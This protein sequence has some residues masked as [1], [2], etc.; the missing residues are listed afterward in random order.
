M[1]CLIC[2]NQD[3]I[4]K[5]SDYKLEIKSD[6]KYFKNCSIYNCSDCDFG[7][8]Y[9]FPSNENLNYFYQNIY[10]AADRPPFWRTENI[11]ELDHLLI[12]DKNLN[13]LL[14]A[15]SL[16]NFNKINSIL[17]FGSGYGDLGFLIKKKFPHVKLFS[18]ENDKY[19]KSIL[20]ERGYK[21]FSSLDEINQKFDLVISL[22]SLEHL[23]NTDVFSKF[24][25]ILNTEGLIFFEVPNCTQEYFDGRIY[26]SPHLLFYT[27]KSLRKLAQIKHYNVLNFSH[28]S[29]S[30]ANDHKYQSDSQEYYYKLKNSKISYLNIKKIMKK[31]LPKSILQFKRFFDNAK[32]VNSQ[33]RINNFVNNVGDNCYIRGIFKKIN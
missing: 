12:N 29:Y 28:A 25:K 2:N 16:I 15:T 27:E 9:P 19:C 17:D 5:F 1:N 30:F 6:E 23:T 26:D 11:N 7:F 13:Y 14:Y 4:K 3:K 22:H 20:A 24:S 10:R 18:C 32:T 21:N 33:D 31:I 8:V